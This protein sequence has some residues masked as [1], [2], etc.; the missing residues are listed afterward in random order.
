MRKTARY[1]QGGGEN[2]WGG[3]IGA[4]E[5]GRKVRR[6]GGREE[7]EENRGNGECGVFVGLRLLFACGGPEFCIWRGRRLEVFVF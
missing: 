1:V 6:R 2:R 7:G 5:G 4:T 3:I